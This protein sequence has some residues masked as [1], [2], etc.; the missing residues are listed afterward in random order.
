[1]LREETEG[2]LQMLLSLRKNGL[3]SL[4]KEVRVFKAGCTPEAATTCRASIPMKLS[5]LRY[6]ISTTLCHKCPQYTYACSCRSHPRQ[7]GHDHDPAIMLGSWRVPTC[8][9]SHMM[10]PSRSTSSYCRSPPRR[11]RCRQEWSTKMLG[12]PR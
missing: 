10:L 7:F 12:R 8:R 4:F 3:T 9:C 2:K 6:M 11:G 5:L 1:M